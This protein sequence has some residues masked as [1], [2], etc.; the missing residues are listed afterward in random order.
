M[1]TTPNAGLSRLVSINPTSI[2]HG[3]T[4]NSPIKRSATPIKAPTESSA[5]ERA[6]LPLP[7][8]TE[9]RYGNQSTHSAHQEHALG[10]QDSFIDGPLAARPHLA[11]HR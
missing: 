6:P 10:E 8:A 11:A 3:L 1:I 5:P 7:K 2:A 4:P 9:I